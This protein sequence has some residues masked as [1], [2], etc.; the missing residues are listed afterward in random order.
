M[1]VLL[2][3]PYYPL[4]E[5]PSPPLGLASIGSVL[6][7]HGIEVRILDFVVFPY[8]YKFLEQVCNDYAP[9]I[10]GATSVTMTFHHAIRIIQDAKAINPDIITV[11]GGPHTS[12]QWKET[13]ALY[14]DLDIIAIGEADD[15]LVHI[16]RALEKNNLRDVRGIVYR[17]GSG[18]E[19]TD[20]KGFMDMGGLPIPARHLLP[21][22]RYRSLGMPV[23]MTT[24]R[25]C[26]YQCIFCVGR[27][28]VGS[29][30][31]YRN[32]DTVADEMNYLDS[33]GFH[34][35]NIADDLFTANKRHCRS[36]CRGLIRKDIKT[37]WTSFA[38]VDTISPALLD[39]MKEAGCRALSFGI[40]TANA[41]ILKTIRKGIN[42]NQV[43]DA[44]KLCV[45]AGI[46]PHASFILGLPGETPDT[47]EETIEFTK[48]LK[49]LGLYSGFHLLAPFPGT[50]IRTHRNRYDIKILTHDWSQY[51]ANRAVVETEKVDRHTLDH[52]IQSWEDDYH[53][54]LSEIKKKMEQGE[55]SREESSQIESLDRIALIY[56]LMMGE[57]LERTGS[58]K[59]PGDS[60]DQTEQLGLLVKKVKP[61]SRFSATRTFEILKH[62][63]DHDGLT[64][65]AVK[66]RIR[67]EWKDYL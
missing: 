59:W 35:I 21:L 20:R 22:G 9:D 30:I 16:I 54:Y 47:L 2:V 19:P 13:M 65:R 31:R 6:E 1:R 57:A 34:Q 42:Q 56:D 18:F 49:D 63:M 10:V 14:P 41:K 3:N 24:S 26:P 58:W 7:Q 25:G 36:I 27:K 66:D 12:F 45:K 15:T 60:V 29:K 52:M 4:S 43:I 8:S 50:R 61:Y 53:T 38:R 44:V 11:M 32:S 51:H 39:T 17:N 55:A 37:R 46:E 67:W 5:T 48:K 23:S 28:M 62:A 40:E 64:C 33:L